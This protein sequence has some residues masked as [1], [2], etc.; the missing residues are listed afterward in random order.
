MDKEMSLYE[1]VMAEAEI[2]DGTDYKAY[3]DSDK[4]AIFTF[5]KYG[6]WMPEGAF[7]WDFVEM[8]TA[9]EKD[10]LTMLNWHKG[11]VKE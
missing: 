6:V 5:A 11:E 7:Q 2:P 4:E 10:L 9:P 8:M 3:T 1:K